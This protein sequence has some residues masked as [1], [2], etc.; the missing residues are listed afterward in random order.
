MPSN[1]SGRSTPLG[2][3]NGPPSG[4]AAP[5]SAGTAGNLGLQLQYHVVFCLWLLSYEDSFCEG[6]NKCVVRALTAL[7]AAGRTAA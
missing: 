7:I 3:L 2:A 4:T 5:S 1:S 6:V